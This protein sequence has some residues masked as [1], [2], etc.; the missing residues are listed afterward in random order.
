MDFLVIHP[1]SPKLGHPMVLGQPWLATPD[2]FITSLFGEMT[3]SNGTQSH[4]LILFPPSQPTMEVPL[5]LENPYGEED[6]TQPLLT[7]EQVKGVQEHSK[8]QILSLFLAASACIDYPQSFP[9]YTH[10]FSPKFQ[11]IWHP[12]T[13]TIATLSQIEEGKDS[14]VQA[15]EISLGKSLY[16]N[17]ILETYQQQNM[18]QRIQG[19]SDVFAWDYSDMKGIHPDTC[20]Y[21]IYTNDQIRPI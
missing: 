6:C 7:L 12:S 3:I 21:H 14:I 11:E 10:I 8:E 17:A 1:K 19:K 9:N 13:S 15:V 18:V 16:I 4:K 2:A 20:M 5:W